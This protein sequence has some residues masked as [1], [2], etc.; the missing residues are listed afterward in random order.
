VRFALGVDPLNKQLQ[1]RAE[2]VAELRS[3]DEATV[4]FTLETEQA[5]NP[6]LR[7][8]DAGIREALGMAD[9]SDHEVFVEL[10][11]RRNNV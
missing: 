8:N 7:L 5:T 10:R 4:P 1:Q 6:F 11:Q 9:A 3:K 2:Q